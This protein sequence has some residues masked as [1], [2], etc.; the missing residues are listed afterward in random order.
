MRIK[1]SRTLAGLG[2]PRLNIALVAELVDA[3]D[4]GSGAVRRG[5]SS[6]SQGTKELDGLPSKGA[7]YLGR[8]GK[9]GGHRL[10][11][12]SAWR[13]QF[14]SVPLTTNHPLGQFRFSTVGSCNGLLIRGSLVRAQ[15]AE[16]Q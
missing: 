16:P 11:L 13:V 6:P 9:V 7:G 2:G 12:V 3:P 1:P 5:G 14:D 15:E 4:L 10:S 8:E